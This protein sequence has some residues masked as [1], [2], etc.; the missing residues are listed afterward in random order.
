MDVVLLLAVSWS[1][2][3]VTPVGAST[4]TAAAQNAESRCGG[5]SGKEL[6]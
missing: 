1:L 5:T 6:E 3:S 4:S 2:L